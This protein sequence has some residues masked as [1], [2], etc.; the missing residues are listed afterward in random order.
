MPMLKIRSGVY[1]LNQLLDGGI[2]ENT[3]TAVIGASGAGKTTFATYFLKRGLEDGEDAIF[4]TLD[5]SPDQIIK[6]VR[7]MGW[8]EIDRYID[9]GSMVFIDASGKQFSDFI[10][11][12]LANFVADWKGHGARIVIDPLTPVLWSVKEK[13]EQRELVSYFLRETRKVGTVLCTLEEHGVTSD[14][15]SPEL[16]I[17]MYLA[18]NVIHLRYRSHESP[19]RREMKIIK[20]RSS[21]HSKFWH[22]YRIVR[23]A[24]ILVESAQDEPQK[25]RMKIDISK[26][27]DRKLTAAQRVRMEGLDTNAKDGLNRT[28]DILAAEELG[29]VDVNKALANILQEYGIQ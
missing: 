3:V 17:P 25:P 28:L 22:P 8:E 13:Y 15:S 7:E 10:R 27:L 12:E 23:G 19:E 1:G 20:C 6:E 26:L 18:D 14:L 16:V 21:K 24:G 9:E 2:N 11:K 4:I 29:D 5:E